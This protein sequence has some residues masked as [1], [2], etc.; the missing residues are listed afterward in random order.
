MQGTAREA[1]LD[2]FAGQAGDDI[3][4]QTLAQDLEATY[5][6]TASP[7]YTLQFERAMV[8][9][10]LQRIYRPDAEGRP[11]FSADAAANFQAMMDGPAND[12]IMQQ[13]KNR[14]YEDMVRE[15]NEHYDALTSATQL[16][17][18]QAREALGQIE[19]SLVEPPPGTA[20]NPVLQ[21]MAPAMSRFMATA[22]QGES[23]RRATLLVS[24]LRAFRQQNGR[25]PADLTE[26]GPGARHA[27]D[28][29][30]GQPFAYRLNG[31]D[32]DLYS[33]GADGVDQGGAAGEDR[34]SGDT[35]YWPRR[36]R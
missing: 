32:F 26:L 5:Q 36:S 7:D 20:A 2:S 12:A 19:R 31:E 14:S 10:T 22:T 6:P 35:R 8:L 18:P 34:L 27:I 9:D 29:F 23:S 15:V 30:T 24:E 4:Y 13:F 33:I 21:I 1:L 25:Y 11:Q 16:P 28:P 3:D 17:Y